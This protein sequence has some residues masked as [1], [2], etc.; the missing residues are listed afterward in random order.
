M[1]AIRRVTHVHVSRDARDCDGRIEDDR[2][3]RLSPDDPDNVWTWYVGHVLRFLSPEGESIERDTTRDGYPRLIVD[4][5]TDEGYEHT[6]LIGCD[7][8]ECDPHAYRYRD[9]TAESMGY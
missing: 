4:R 7:D 9:H 1:L 8:P 3:F 5:Q 6:E 2:V